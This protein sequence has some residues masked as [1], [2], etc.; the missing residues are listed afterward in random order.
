[1]RVERRNQE[2]RQPRGQKPERVPLC[3]VCGAQG[4]E[5]RSDNDVNHLCIS[6]NH[7]WGISCD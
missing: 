3:P 7:T 2:P 1:M 5:L 6:C 4:L